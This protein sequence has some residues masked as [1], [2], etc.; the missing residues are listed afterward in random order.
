ML[1]NKWV[2]C[3]SASEHL[4]D[5]KRV[6]SRSKQA[7]TSNLPS[8]VLDLVQLFAASRKEEVIPKISNF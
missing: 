3:G 1:L 8:K 5:G 2:E 4:S 6:F 7:K